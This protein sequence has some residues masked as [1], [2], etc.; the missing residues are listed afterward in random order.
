[1]SATVESVRTCDGC[2]RHESSTRKP[3]GLLQPLQIPEQTCES[4]SMDLITALPMT[5]KGHDAIVVF[6][7]RL[8]KMVHFAPTTSGVTAQGVAS[9]LGVST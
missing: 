4:V 7:D 6:V 3:I 8:S 1:M 5:A 2:Q 9:L